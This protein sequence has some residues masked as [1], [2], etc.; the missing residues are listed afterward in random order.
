LRRSPKFPR[1][2]SF[3]RNTICPEE[4]SNVKREM[5]IFSDPGDLFKKLSLTAANLGSQQIFDSASPGARPVLE[6]SPC[7]VL[8]HDM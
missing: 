4:N 2:R 6:L 5:R 7:S 1:G 3:I 8:F